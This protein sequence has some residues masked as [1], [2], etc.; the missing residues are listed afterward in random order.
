[1]KVSVCI[2]CYEANGRGAELLRYSLIR[3]HLQTFKDLEVCVTDHSI[4][5]EIEDVCKEFSSAMRVS[6]YRIQE[7]HG[8]S[9][10]NTN[11]SMLRA[12]GE[13]LKLLQ[14]DDYL[15]NEQAIQKTVDAFNNPSVVWLANAYV[16]TQDK[17]TFFNYHLPKVNPQIETVNTIGCPSC[18][19]VRNGK[20]ELFDDTMIWYF[21]CEQYRRM[22]NKYGPPAIIEEP[23]MVNYLWD[24]Q[25][26]NT[27][28]NEELRKREFEY[29]TKKYS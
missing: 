9:S 3:I 7:R 14:Q 16:H 1:M 28:A 24:G 12:N 29:V 2:P 10:Y 5:D 27:L 26:T 15:L 11:Q 19:S 22:I 18:I 25:V 13:I 8:S 17:I 20:F 21:D 4:N 6:Y 23:F